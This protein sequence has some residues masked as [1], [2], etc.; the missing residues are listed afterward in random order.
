MISNHRNNRVIESRVGPSYDIFGEVLQVW[1]A[2]YAQ[3]FVESERVR[4]RCVG[5]R[6]DIV[7][8]EFSF[9]EPRLAAYIAFR[10]LQVLGAFL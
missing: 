4:L 6:I 9:R 10:L 3:N 8:S 1:D 2:C 7:L 5:A